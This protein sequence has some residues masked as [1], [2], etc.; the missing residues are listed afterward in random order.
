MSDILCAGWH[1]ARD[2]GLLEDDAPIRL[3]LCLT[4]ISVDA[5][6][7]HESD[8]NISTKEYD[9]TG[10]SRAEPTGVTW[11][12]D[13]TADEM[14]LDM[15]DDAEAFGASPVAAATTAPVGML[16]IL[17][18]DGTAANDYVLGYSDSGSYANG[19]GGSL[20]LVVPVGGLLYSK[21][22]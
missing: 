12:Y 3:A 19:N 13:A 4:G 1:A 18:V 14:Q 9:G 20:G 15:D 2:A 22:G 6:D 16:V 11:Q 21:Q 8:T 10:Y 5:D 7:V 17:E